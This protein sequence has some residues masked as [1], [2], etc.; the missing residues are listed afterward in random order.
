MV[1]CICM[2]LYVGIDE[3]RVYEELNI[4]VI[5]KNVE[6]HGAFIRRLRLNLVKCLKKVYTKVYI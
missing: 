2:K 3:R 6:Y 4:E 1:Y 5:V